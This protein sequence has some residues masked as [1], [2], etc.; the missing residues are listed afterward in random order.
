MDGL[1]FQ[2]VVSQGGLGDRVPVD[3]PTPAVDEPRLEHAHEGVANG[4]GADLIQ[5]EACPLPVAGAPHALQL[6]EDAVAILLPPGPDPP[7]QPFPAQV[8]TGLALLLQN[9]PLDHALG[10]DPGVIGAGHPKNILPPHPVEA[11]ED[12]LEGVV[13]GVAHVQGPG[14]VGRGNDYRVRFA[15]GGRVG[16]EVAA[17]EPELVGALLDGVRLVAG[18]QLSHFPLG[19]AVLHLW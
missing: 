15:P 2:F 14:D 17:L 11:Y 8:V 1:V 6:S 10:G 3:E 4:P 5:S 16:V 12:V 18:L 7:H 19:R 13:K 9:L